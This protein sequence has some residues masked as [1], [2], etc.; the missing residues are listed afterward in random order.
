MDD[1]V[2]LKSTALMVAIKLDLEAEMIL[3]ARIRGGITHRLKGSM[4][5][6]NKG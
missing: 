1:E 4:D 6:L 3:I 5:M 2:T